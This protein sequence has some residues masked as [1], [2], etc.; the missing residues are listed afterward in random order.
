LRNRYFACS[1]NEINL[2]STFQKRFAENFSAALGIE[3]SYNFWGKSWGKPDYYIRLGDHWNILSDKNSP[4]YGYKIYFGT[5]SNDTYFVGKGWSTNT[6]SIFGEANYEPVEEITMLLS[7]RVDKD[8]FSDWLFSPRIAVIWEMNDANYLKLIAQRSL[9]MN[10]A[11]ELLILDF[12]N[13]DPHS[14]KLDNIEL[15]FTRMETTNLL[16]NF[17]TFI[18]W[19]DI[20][21][22]NDPLRSTILSGKLSM[23][24]IEFDG[25]YSI[26]NIDLVFNH[27]FYKQIKW[28]LEPGIFESGISYSDYYKEYFGSVL[29]DT[30]NDLNNISKNT[31]KFAINWKLFNERIILH[32]DSRIYWDFTGAQDGMKMMKNAIPF[33]SDSNTVKGIIG[34]IEKYDTYGT[35]IRINGSIKVSPFY[36]F[37]I[38]LYGMNLLDLTNNKRLRYDTGSKEEKYHYIMK[39]GL[40]VEPLTIGLKLSYQY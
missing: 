27:A 39:N 3:Y 25:K 16:F 13:N 34:L 22:W 37:D 4:A 20:L 24:G 14:E 36:N 35:D 9:R 10:T 6:I 1:E 38:T 32:L 11:E 18:S 29:S 8:D 19:M 40:I 28:K 21:S 12:E 33:C 7:A 5:D 23:W 15:I 26:S 17:S 31:S 30:G 2:I